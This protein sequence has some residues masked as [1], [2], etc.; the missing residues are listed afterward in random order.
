MKDIEIVAHRGASHDFPE[1]TLPAFEAAWERKAD[2]I[3]GDFYLTKDGKIV[4]MHDST[5]DRTSNGSLS[6]AEATYD[7]LRA[8][9][10]GS[11]KGRQ[12][13]GTRIPG[14]EEVLG[15]IP[16]DKKIFIEI[17]CGVEIL[18]PLHQVIGN[19]GL[20]PQQVVIISFQREVISASKQLLS[21]CKALW[22]TSFRQHKETAKWNPGVE[23]VLR[24]LEQ[25]GADGVDCKAHDLVDE[26]FV[27][28]I[29]RSGKELH[30][31]TVDDVETARR[32]T[33]LGI[34]SLTTNRPG[35]LRTRLGIAE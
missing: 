29:R 11:W 8:L 16:K 35:W 28:A 5:T 10:F 2:T 7:E 23:E 4:C 24:V 12:W 32:L 9:D 26:G 6:V 13:A 25:T 1:N 22:L 20:K 18:P 27:Q 19:S 3:E 15:A 33:N 14:I 17:K 30:T 34:D 31:W 21:D